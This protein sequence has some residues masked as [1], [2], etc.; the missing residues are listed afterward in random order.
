MMLNGKS[1]SFFLSNFVVFLL[2]FFH[3]SASSP[4]FPQPSS[5]KHGP[6]SHGTDNGTSTPRFGNKL[7][8]SQSRLHERSPLSRDNSDHERGG[9]LPRQPWN[10]HV[11]HKA[12]SSQN[13]S[14]KVGSR[15]HHAADHISVSTHLRVISRNALPILRAICM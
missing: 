13:A 1:A 11:D 14:Q 6:M 7:S 12:L 4:E 10:G 9:H 2:I 8:S 3:V 15:S 5:L